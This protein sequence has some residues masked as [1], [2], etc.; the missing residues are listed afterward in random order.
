[1][2]AIEQKPTVETT[3][4]P[5]EEGSDGEHGFECV[6]DPAKGGGL[7]AV[8]GRKIRR[9]ALVAGI[10]GLVLVGVLVG[11]VVSVVGKSDSNDAS[12]S[13]STVNNGEE[14]DFSDVGPD[15]SQVTEPTVPSSGT[16][17]D[18]PSIIQNPFPTNSPSIAPT[19][20]P[21]P[22]PTKGPSPS[23]TKGPSPSPTAAPTTSPTSLPISLPTSL[24][25]SLPTLSP[26]KFPSLSPSTEEQHPDYTSQLTFCVIAVRSN[27]L[28]V[29]CRKEMGTEVVFANSFSV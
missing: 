19:K 5:S 24:P 13:M 3:D 17:A 7:L 9:T 2:K 22:S 27:F 12:A 11:V 18:A 1:M 21:S 29:V 6:A 23:P 8:G 26:T 16:D 15:F 20:R 4:G 14:F 25:S 28:N 10:V